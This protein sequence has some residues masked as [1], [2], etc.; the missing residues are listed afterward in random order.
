MIKENLVKTSASPNKTH[1]VEVYEAEGG[2]TVGRSVRVYLVE[3][4]KKKRIYDKYHDYE[5][6]INWISEDVIQINDVPLDLSKG[7]TYDK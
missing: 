6:N 2:A 1:N 3:D 5:E 4:G 7:E